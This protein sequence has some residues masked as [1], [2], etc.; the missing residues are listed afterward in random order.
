MPPDAYWPAIAN[1]QN[2]T[3]EDHA[4]HTTPRGV[5]RIE[6]VYPGLST[7]K[8]SKQAMKAMK[9]QIKMKSSV[10]FKAPHSRRS[11]PRKRKKN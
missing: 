11:T 4:A 9:P 6:D 10:K 7:K 5:R 3:A 8:F 1:P 2:I